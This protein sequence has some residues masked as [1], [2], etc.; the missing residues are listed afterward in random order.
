M[1]N[2]C[3]EFLNSRRREYPSGKLIEDLLEQ[4]QWVEQFLD[5]WNL[6]VDQLLDAN[7]LAALR[8]LRSRLSSVVEALVDGQPLSAKELG[9][10]NEYLDRTP[11]IQRLV[12]SDGGYRLDLVPQQ[13][14][15]HWVQGEIV[16]AFLDLLT[17]HDPSRIK[18]CSNPACRYVYYD[19]CKNRSRQWC[20]DGCAN[21][22]RVRRFRAR[23]KAASQQEEHAEDAAR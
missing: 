20:S 16:A 1:E 17:Q 6:Q 10:V 13:R 4:P 7:H 8:S 23:H 19:E 22:M 21:R 3:L 12:Q 11:F 14:D 5:K 18:I 9:T 2:I 15:W